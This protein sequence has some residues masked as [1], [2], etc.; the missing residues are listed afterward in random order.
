MARLLL[1]A[2]IALFA[3]LAGSAAPAASAPAGHA[4]PP[5][6]IWSAPF[7]LFLLAIAFL[8]QI[9]RLAHW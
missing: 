5:S 4:T 2:L 8:P 9:P 1:T 7:A 3:P 6:V